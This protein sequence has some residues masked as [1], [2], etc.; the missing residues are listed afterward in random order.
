MYLLHSPIPSP[1][2]KLKIPKPQIDIALEAHNGEPV[3]LYDPGDAGEVRYGLLHLLVAFGLEV[4]SHRLLPEAAERVQ[5]SLVIDVGQVVLLERARA[6][7]PVLVLAALLNDL[8]YL[9]ARKEASYLEVV[10]L[11]HHALEPVLHHVSH[12]SF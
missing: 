11:V 9:P 12:F 2:A 5:L 4:T 7:E 3:N 1:P 8:G 10:E 6:L